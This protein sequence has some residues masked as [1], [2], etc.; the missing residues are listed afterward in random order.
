MTEPPLPLLRLSGAGRSFDNGRIVALWPTTLK[1][2][3]GELLAVTGAS[4]S[5][6]STLL[7]ML[8]GIDAPNSGQVQFK[9]VTAPTAVQW[10]ALRARTIGVISQDF[11]LL[12]ALTAVENVEVAMIGRLRGSHER[13]QEALARLAEAGVAEVANRKPPELSGGERRR[14]GVAR[15][16]ANNPELVLADEP[17]SNLDSVTGA[18]VLQLLLSLHADRGVTMIIV[19]H[20]ANVVEQCPRHIAMADGRI[21]SDER[22]AERANP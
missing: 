11:N 5:G 2:D 17:T 1:V 9:T 13:R 14:V 18:A 16:L 21:L 15:A 19:T 8:S 10:A 4:G 20:D 6:K 22:R 3:Q 12:P 7:N